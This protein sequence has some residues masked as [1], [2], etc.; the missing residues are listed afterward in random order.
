M[1]ALIAGLILFAFLPNFI[2]VA[3]DSEVREN[4]NAGWVRFNYSTNFSASIEYTIEE[5]VLTIG[6]SAPQSG[7][8]E[9]TIIWS[10]SYLCVYI[11][12][13]TPR[14]VGSNSGT[15]STGTLSDNFTITK[16]ANDTR[17]TDGVDT[18]YFTK[19]IW[20]YIPNANG[21]F[22]SFVSGED[23]HIDNAA[24]TRPFVGGLLGVYAYND[25][26]TNGYDL[27]LDVDKDGYVINGGEWKGN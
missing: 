17:I 16:G 8:V 12:D 15:V 25:M 5:S 7:A 19:A 23:S 22:A 26:N 18:Y 24:Y 13:G 6:G 1:T 20:A 11:K 9:D 27:Y 10:D 14:Y 21:K 2:S 3:Y 4:E